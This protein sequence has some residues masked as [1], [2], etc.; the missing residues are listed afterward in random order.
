MDL[1]QSVAHLHRDSL[2]NLTRSASSPGQRRTDAA[3]SGSVRAPAAQRRPYPCPPPLSPIQGILAA[4]AAFSGSLVV[5]SPTYRLAPA[6][7]RDPLATSPARLVECSL[8]ERLAPNGPPPCQV[9]TVR[10]LA[11]RQAL[12]LVPRSRRQSAATLLLVRHRRG[13][14]PASSPQI[15]AFDLGPPI[16]R[17]RLATARLRHFLPYCLLD[18]QR[19]Y[20]CGPVAVLPLKLGPPVV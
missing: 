17:S 18:L 10:P 2:V 11:L 13:T 7:E 4:L 9:R 12:G 6:H 15:A 20:S 3:T 8:S 19:Q 5:Q 1:E 16:W 14:S